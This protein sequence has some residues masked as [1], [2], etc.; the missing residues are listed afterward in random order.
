MGDSLP[1]QRTALSSVDTLK[2]LCLDQFGACT[3]KEFR[4]QGGTESLKA[5][6]DFCF[7]ED[8]K[9]GKNRIVWLTENAFVRL[10]SDFGLPSGC[11]RDQRFDLLLW[12]TDDGGSPDHELSIYSSTI[13]ELIAALDLLVGLQD[14]YYKRIELQYYRDVSRICPLTGRHLENFVRNANRENTFW[15]MLFTRDQ[16]RTLS[17]SGIRTNIGFIVCR[18]EDEGITF[19]EAS[20]ARENQE[21]G[22]AKLT[23]RRSLLFDEENFRLF[24][25]QHRL[26]SLAL[27]CISFRH[28]EICR[29]LAATADLQN[30]ELHSCQLADGGA[31]LVE[32]VREGRG[33]R[34]LSI[35][36]EI[37]DSLERF[38]SFISAL[39]GNM[40][41]QRLELSN[42][43]S[44]D[45]S[46]QALA[47][48]LLENK[49]LVHFV[50]DKCRLDGRCWSELMAAISMNSTLRTL[51]FRHIYDVDR[52]CPRSSENRDRTKAVADMLLINNH[53]DKIPVSFCS[54]VS[55]DR[56]DWDALVAPRVE[57][58]LYRKRFV[59]IQKIQDPSTRAA[60]VGRALARV[61]KNPSLV[62]MV[63]SQNHDVVCSYLDEALTACE[64][65]ISAPG[66][67]K[68][69][70]S[71]PGCFFGEILQP[72][73]DELLSVLETDFSCPEFQIAATE[74]RDFM[75]QK[76]VELRGRL[77]H[78]IE[79][80]SVSDK[81]CSLKDS[82]Q[83]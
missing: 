55:F 81:A 15:G 58:N 29:A 50:L 59:A 73:L 26:E 68:R 64:D 33:S 11:Y 41:L 74:V 19:V 75:H 13:E 1:E 57:C 78:T 34:G 10:G 25:S 9:Y 42:I 27:Y 17:T 44:G 67:R 31:A 43:S 24:L 28:E 21:S 79:G 51:N 32:S 46:S 38:L 20:A 49:G 16:C 72:T 12:A 71:L 23:I 40:Y 6:V 76:V 35:G 47:R 56:E 3:F 60:V 36:W 4:W 8:M 45:S 53:I 18:F 37:F 2:Q 83:M 61:E 22:P 70:R 69:K 52:R 14:S 80:R 5:F 39:R 54:E 63:L 77:A 65:Q 66:S 48:A 82:P 7:L 62:W 30:L